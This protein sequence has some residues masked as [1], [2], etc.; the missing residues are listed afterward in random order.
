MVLCCLIRGDLHT[1]KSQEQPVGLCILY[2]LNMLIVKV[3]EEYNT[4]TETAV[5]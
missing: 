4:A 1:P 5:A 3:V 2:L